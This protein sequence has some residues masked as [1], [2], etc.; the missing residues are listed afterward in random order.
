MHWLEKIKETYGRYLWGLQLI[1][2]DSNTGDYTKLDRMIRLKEVMQYFIFFNRSLVLL[3]DMECSK[4][5]EDIQTAQTQS[6]TKDLYN[7]SRFNTRFFTT[8]DREL[9]YHL[10]RRMYNLLQ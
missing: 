1:K 9:S 10:M 8:S 5:L 2:K 7:F 3:G 4:F 6:W